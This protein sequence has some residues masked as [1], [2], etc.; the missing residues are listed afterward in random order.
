MSER[1]IRGT[2]STYVQPRPVR[3]YEYDPE[4]Q[5]LAALEQEAKRRYRKWRMV[6]SDIEASRRVQRD[7]ANTDPEQS[8]IKYE[9]EHRAMFQA[10]AESL[11]GVLRN[12][13]HE[14]RHHKAEADGYRAQINAIAERYKVS[15]GVMSNVEM[16][17]LLQARR[18]DAAAKVESD[19]CCGEPGSG[20]FCFAFGGP[21]PRVKEAAACHR[22]AQDMVAWLEALP[23]E[24]ALADDTARL[25]VPNPNE[26]TA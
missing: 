24:T 14:M 1:R 19:G 22:F 13:W 16:F 21:C 15:D 26:V 10:A 9:P 17:D 12:V 3:G 23:N 20:E 25:D 18:Q 2:G 5:R 4:V 11:R 8:I 7:H 6:Y